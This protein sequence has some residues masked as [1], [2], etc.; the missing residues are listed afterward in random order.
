MLTKNSV[1]RYLD[2]AELEDGKDFSRVCLV[3]NVRY[4]TSVLG[5][6]YYTFYLQDVNAN[7]ITARLFDITEFSDSGYTATYL[8]NKPVTIY[9][10]AQIYE[11]S[12]SLILQNIRLYSGEFDYQ[13]FRGI[14]PSVNIEWLKN[15]YS[16]I[17]EIP[18]YY[19]TKCIPEFCG[20]RSG[21][22]LKVLESATRVLEG[23]KELVDFEKLLRVCSRAFTV[24]VKY[25]MKKMEFSSVSDA[26]V[27]RLL[28][29]ELGTSEETEVINTCY[30]LLGFR[31]AN[32]IYAHLVKQAI[33]TVMEAYDMLYF[34]STMPRGISTF[35]RGKEI[36]K[37]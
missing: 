6:G 1:Q 23:Y 26:D 13:I 36:I 20:G 25:L 18:E 33:E 34:E 11:G 19:R 37:Y 31:T 22:A 17:S 30:A 14:A 16:G 9:F 35:Y 24:Y 12:W 28:Q 29:V 15:I 4:G 5:K 7:T 10:T 2:L 27:V 8:K 3:K 32:N 21:G